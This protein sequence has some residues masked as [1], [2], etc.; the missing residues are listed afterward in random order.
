MKYSFYQRTQFS[1]MELVIRRPVCAFMNLSECVSHEFR[2]GFRNVAKLA[3]FNGV[4]LN[5]PVSWLLVLLKIARAQQ[6]AWSRH[7]TKMGF[8]I[9][10]NKETQHHVI[11]AQQCDKPT[12]I[13]NLLAT[14]I[15]NSPEKVLCPI[16][17]NN[18]SLNV[19]VL[20]YLLSSH[21]DCS[22]GLSS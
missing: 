20:M 19:I 4:F 15:S 21:I 18:N 17:A 3:W 22:A 5:R 13:V 12:T 10:T 1:P 8:F 2:Y 6:T 16:H 9:C 11:C 14:S 7:S